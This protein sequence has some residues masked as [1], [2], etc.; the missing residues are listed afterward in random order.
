MYIYVLDTVECNRLTIVYL[1]SL[2]SIF[3]FQVEK[4]FQ[5]FRILNFV[6][7]S[8]IYDTGIFENIWITCFI[9]LSCYLVKRL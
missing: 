8:I 5:N 7:S 3:F 2:K 1:S 6:L 4:R 9:V